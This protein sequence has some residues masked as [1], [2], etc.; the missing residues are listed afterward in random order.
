[1]E[2]IEEST[3]GKSDAAEKSM[4]QKGKCKTTISGGSRGR[5]LLLLWSDRVSVKLL[6]YSDAHIDVEIEDGP[7]KFRFTRVYGNYVSTKETRNVE[8]GRYFKGAINLTVV[9]RR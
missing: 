3:E 4:V 7:K 2:G 8:P 5:G 6:S 9:I 1:M